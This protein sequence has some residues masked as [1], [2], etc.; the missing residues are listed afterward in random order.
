MNV[1]GFHCKQNTYRRKNRS[2]HCTLIVIISNPQ[3]VSL[4]LFKMS[5]SVALQPLSTKDGDANIHRRKVSQPSSQTDTPSK[6]DSDAWLEEAHDINASNVVLDT[7]PFT[8]T[9]TYWIT[10]H[11]LL[12]QNITIFD[13]TKD[14]STPYT[15]LTPAYKSLIYKALKDHSHTPILTCHR[16]SWL[17][18][19]Y[20]ITDSSAR[21][22]ATWSHGWS[23]CR[24]ATLTFPS[25]S[26]HAAHP[27]TLRNKGWGSR[28]QTFTL[29]SQP[30][31]WESDSMWHSSNMTLYKVC[32]NSKSKSNGSG[33][34]E[35]KIPVGKYAQKCWGSWV[36]GGTFVLDGKEIDGVVACL[37]L[38]VVLKKKRQRR[39]ERG[40]GGGGP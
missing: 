35:T 8:P 3:G 27:I 31:V 9:T 13:L 4:S 14:I 1:K 5:Q 28:S 19:Q 37:T 15:G 16:S 29:D 24:A 20:T 7:S 11:G 12:T 25:D 21:P 10:P 18:L 33:E 22:L 39:A 17:G 23:S 34:R 38:C 36:T 6:H 40:N 32:R 26:A 30:F 2:F